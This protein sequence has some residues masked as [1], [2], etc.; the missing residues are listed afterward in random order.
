MRPLII[1]M[2]PAKVYPTDAWH[3]LSPSTANLSYLIVGD[4][5]GWPMVEDHFDA[6]NLNR[7]WYHDDQMNEDT[8]LPSDGE[9]TLKTRAQAGDLNGGRLVFLLGKKVTD[10]VFNFLRSNDSTL[11]GNA[12]NQLPRCKGYHLCI[13]DRDA[14]VDKPTGYYNFTAIPLWHPRNLTAPGARMPSGWQ[15]QMSN[16]LRSAAGLTERSFVPPP[17]KAGLQIT[18]IDRNHRK[19]YFSRYQMELTQAD[20]AALQQQLFPSRWTSPIVP[21]SP[22]G[23]V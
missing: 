3:P 22:A 20:L 18:D 2:G 17:G 1:G 14:R 10:F 15:Q 19:R 23:L 6:V 21:L 16:T 5:L 12:W 8:I 9:E 13:E 11:A 4:Y 7:N